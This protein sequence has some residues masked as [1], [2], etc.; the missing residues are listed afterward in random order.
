MG[1]AQGGY[2][3]ANSPPRVSFQP[4]LGSRWLAREESQPSLRSKWPMVVPRIKMAE[5]NQGVKEAP[6]IRGFIGITKSDE[7]LDRAYLQTAGFFR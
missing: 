1:N 2:N 7:P 5:S 3:I 6:V 4:W